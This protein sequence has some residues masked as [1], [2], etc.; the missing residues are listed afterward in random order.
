[1]GRPGGGRISPA[2][3]AAAAPAA[4]A[5]DVASV[6]LAEAAPEGSLL[7]LSVVAV[8]E[9]DSSSS[10]LTPRRSLA[11]AVSVASPCCL[12]HD[13]MKFTPSLDFSDTVG[14]VSSGKERRGKS[15]LG[16]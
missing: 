2:A 16:S 15:Q 11:S 6:E 5:A 10:G 9:G 14:L 13:T 1:M 12:A 4:A 8:P 7:L 3:A